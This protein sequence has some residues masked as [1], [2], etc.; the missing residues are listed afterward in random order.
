MEKTFRKF[1]VNNVVGY[2]D[3]KENQDGSQECRSTVDTPQGIVT[4][5]AYQNYRDTPATLIMS[6]IYDGHSYTEEIWRKQEFTSRSISV[7][8]GKFA[9]KIENHGEDI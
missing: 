3:F 9:R 4:V 7:L 1:K 8:V 6:I 2:C 5:Y